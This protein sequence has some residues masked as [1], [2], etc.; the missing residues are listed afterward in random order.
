MHHYQLDPAHY[1]TS[2]GFSW[3]ALLKTTNANLEL[4]DDYDMHLFIENGMR[5]GISMVSK[6]YSKANNKYLPDYD[7]NLPSKYIHYLDAN[8]LYGLAMVQPLPTG[9]FE[10]DNTDI[11]TILKHPADDP[12]GYIVEVDLE[13]PKELHKAHNAYPLAT[14]KL[15]VDYEW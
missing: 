7:K 3:D 2:P 12:K 13:Y 6:R 14:E 10:W 5:G 11:Q 9:G 1:Y 15:I 8:N 4:F